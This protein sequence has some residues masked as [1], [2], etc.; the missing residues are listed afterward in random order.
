MSAKD[1]KEI[2]SPQFELPKGQLAHELAMLSL[3]RMITDA[4]TPNDIYDKY[5]A[6][7]GEFSAR[8]DDQTRYEISHRRWMEATPLGESEYDCQEPPDERSPK[9]PRR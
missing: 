5:L 6:L 1:P 7:L 2:H 3:S 8:I 9:H 4:D